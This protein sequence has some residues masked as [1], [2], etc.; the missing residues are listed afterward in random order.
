MVGIATRQADSV[1]SRIRAVLESREAMTLPEL[2]QSVNADRETV[3]RELREGVHA[4]RI[5]RLAPVPGRSRAELNRH[6][7]FAR[8]VYY[9]W[10]RPTD[11]RHLWQ[12]RLLSEEDVPPPHWPATFL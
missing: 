6:G 1:Q 8:Y 3:V 11:D 4:R 10:R 2:V 5:E 7:P 9:R 12:T